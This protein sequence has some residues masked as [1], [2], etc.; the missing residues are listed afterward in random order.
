MKTMVARVMG[1]LVM[2]G[3][4]MLFW[5]CSTNEVS[6]ADPTG[7]YGINGTA[8][9]KHDDNMTDLT[10]TDLQGMV[11][12]K[13][14]SAISVSKGII[15]VGKMTDIDAND[16]TGQVSIYRNGMLLTKASIVGTINEHASLTAT[17][18]GSGA[19]N[20]TFSLNYGE[21]KQRS[22]SA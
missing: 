14:F 13:E 6:N 12:G 17:L 19:G 15:Y 22:P 18:I 2:L 21:E 20:G 3:G 8:S 9:V 4:V 10:M 11:N 5:G 1:T 7:F 16:F